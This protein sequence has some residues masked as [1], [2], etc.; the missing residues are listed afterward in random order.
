MSV[1]NR[2]NE[3]T[4]KMVKV[5]IELPEDV[6]EKAQY[7]QFRLTSKKRG[8]VTIADA[9]SDMIARVAK[10]IKIPTKIL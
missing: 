8:K 4:G 10:K 2:E 7:H 3:G 6:H 9:C 5:L 1:E